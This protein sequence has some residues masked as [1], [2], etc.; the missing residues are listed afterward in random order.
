[1]HFSRNY[2]IVRACVLFVTGTLISVNTLHYT[3]YL[4]TYRLFHHTKYYGRKTFQSQPVV[5]TRRY[6]KRV[7]LL[8][9]QKSFQTIVMYTA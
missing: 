5:R 4:L 3:V 8:K 6:Y 1:M 7:I 2:C 9:R